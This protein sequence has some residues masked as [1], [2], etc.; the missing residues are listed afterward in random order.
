[1]NLVN[2]TE[3]LKH[4]IG[5]PRGQKEQKLEKRPQK[6]IGKRVPSIEKRNPRC[7]HS[8][9]GKGQNQRTGEYREAGKTPHVLVHFS[10]PEADH[11]QHDI[12]KDH[13]KRPPKEVLR[14]LRKDTVKAQKKRAQIGS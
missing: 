8:G 2:G 4:A 14:N 13:P 6:I 3:V 12:R 10:L 7:V 1:M 11:A 9:G 5:K